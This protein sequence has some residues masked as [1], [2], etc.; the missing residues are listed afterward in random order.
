MFCSSCKRVDLELHEIKR[1][2]CDNG[3]IFCKTCDDG[4]EN[5]I[6]CG[7]KVK[8]FIHV[9]INNDIPRICYS[10]IPEPSQDKIEEIPVKATE[11]EDSDSDSSFL[12]I[13]KGLDEYENCCN[14]A[15]CE[16]KPIVGCIQVIGHKHVD[17]T[18][19]VILDEEDEKE[20]IKNFS[21]IAEVQ[22]EKPIVKVHESNVKFCNST[23]SSKKTQILSNKPESSM[24]SP[25]HSSRSTCFG[26]S[27]ESLIVNKS[28]SREV[29]SE[30]RHSCQTFSSRSECFVDEVQSVVENS[31]P[32]SAYQLY[33]NEA[34]I[35]ESETANFTSLSASRI[36][37]SPPE[38][39]KD[40]KTPFNACRVKFT[41]VY[42]CEYNFPA[43]MEPVEFYEPEDGDD[44]AES[45][46]NVAL[47]LPRL[48]ITCPCSFCEMITTPTD[49]FSHITIDHPYIETVKLAPNKVVNCVFSPS[50]NVNFVRCHQMFL[51]SGK[52]INIG[53]GP[54]K[55][56][57]P[58]LLLTCKFN[59]REIFGSSS[60]SNQASQKSEEVLCV[61]LT[62]VYQHPVNYS[63]NVWKHGRDIND[64]N[65]IKC[66]STSSSCL[67]IKETNIQIV[68]N[69][70]S[71]TNDEYETVKDEEDMIH[72]QIVFN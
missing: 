49:F 43:Q 53:Y 61:W 21:G 52:M 44:T 23:S 7:Q 28:S 45:L 29:F 26:D 22:K 33:K 9:E 65:F 39:K 48:P 6:I 8:N 59:L 50:G 54:F 1:R 37:A 36:E 12:E 19:S 30:S 20:M 5:C 62:S 46:E 38:E 60:M 14:K 51:L 57:L 27:G 69:V 24:K 2:I 10:E 42:R 40:S 55:N 25:I 34:A 16:K 15:E 72:C 70:L 4:A 13:M 18:L 3:H 66:I 64:Q 56:C 31:Q 68:T 11:T 58:I 41:P 67:N 63:L 71:L 17:S 32:A 47:N 35:N